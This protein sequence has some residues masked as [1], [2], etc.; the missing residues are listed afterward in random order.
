MSSDELAFILSLIPDR[1]RPLDPA[2]DQK[3]LEIGLELAER[4]CPTGSNLRGRLIAIVLRL[5]EAR[6]LADHELLELARYWEVFRAQ[7]HSIIAARLTSLLGS[8][9]P[10]ALVEYVSKCLSSVGTRGKAEI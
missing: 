7:S 6:I 8:T 9:P 5:I 3:T 2:E 10:A 1:A 4:L